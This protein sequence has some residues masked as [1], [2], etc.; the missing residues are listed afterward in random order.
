MSRSALPDQNGYAYLSM[1]PFHV[2]VFLLPLVVLYE[3]GSALYLSNA[4]TGTFEQIRAARL[5]SNFF[6]IFGVGGV[7]LPGILLVVVLLVWHILTQDPWRVRGHVLLW[8]IVESFAWTLPLLV[9]S[10]LV[11]SAFGPGSGETQSLLIMAGA[12]AISQK[13]LAARL[14]IAIGAGLYEE[15]L[16]RMVAIALLH[17]ILVDLF[18]LRDSAGKALAVIGAATA[19]ALY[20]DVTLA[21]GAIDWAGFLTFFFAGLYFGA[22]YVT[23]GF[24]IVVAVHAI[25]DVIVLALLGAP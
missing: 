14:T 15:L 13:S 7:Y 12:E 4:V 10:R 17:L 18:R 5:L 3:L 25:Y 8:M 2:L 22:L 21:T 19:F 16:F 11:S 6:E 9:M 23:R 24:G 20:H 1:R